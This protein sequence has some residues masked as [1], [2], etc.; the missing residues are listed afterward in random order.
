MRTIRRI[1]AFGLLLGISPS[2]FAQNGAPRDPNVVV[3]TGTRFTYDLIERWIDAYS[4]VRPGVQIVVEYRGTADPD[5]YDILVE[6]YP[7]EEAY[8]RNRHYVY[9]GRYAIVPVARAGSPFAEYYSNKGVTDETFRRVFFRDLFIEKAKHKELEIPYTV[10]T[11]LQKAGVPKVFAAH[12]GYEQKDIK[13]IAIAGADKHSLKAF[14]RDSIGVTYLPLPL[15]YDLDTRK[16]IAGLTV[17]PPDLN[18]NNRVTDDEK[19]YDRLDDVIQ[20]LEQLDTKHIRN[21]PISHVHLS[22]DKQTASDEAI[23]FL[24]WIDENGRKDLH[25]FGYLQLP[26][27][28]FAKSRFD[29]S[30]PQ[31]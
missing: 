16:P 23:A 14:L 20:R 13:G 15:I 7:H 4:A 27:N 11:R 8:A 31:R 29:R 18:G 28:E 9:V 24:K 22:V 17:L 21:I 12:F 10:Y 5:R 1:F 30:G 25:R 3:V 26:L 19:F 6:V 2:L